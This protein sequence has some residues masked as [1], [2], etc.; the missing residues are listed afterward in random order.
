MATL[1]SDDL[2]AIKQLIEVTFDEKLEEKLDEKLS[3]LPT[4]LVWVFSPN[5]YSLP[6][7]KRKR[8]NSA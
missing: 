7:Y 1:D 6:F 3:P 8:A 4:K 5:L 2:N